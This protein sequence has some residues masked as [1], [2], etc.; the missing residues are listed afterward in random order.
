MNPL[1]ASVPRKAGLGPGAAAPAF[2][3]AMDATPGAVFAPCQRP[4]PHP[5]AAP[6]GQGGYP[7]GNDMRGTPPRPPEGAQNRLVLLTIQRSGRILAHRWGRLFHASFANAFLMK[8]GAMP[9]SAC[10]STV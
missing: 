10:T 4:L 7:P 2:Q 3:G 5:G 9:S 8:K 1:C 6:G